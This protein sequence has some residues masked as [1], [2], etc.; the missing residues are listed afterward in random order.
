MDFTVTA[1]VN[2]LAISRLTY[3]RFGGQ[4]GSRHGLALQTRF[5]TKL[6]LVWLRDLTPSSARVDE[7]HSPT[8]IS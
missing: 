2:Y 8:A 5:P 7:G 4:E 3:R 6:H 1:R